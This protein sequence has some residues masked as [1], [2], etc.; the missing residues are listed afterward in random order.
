MLKQ[1]SYNADPII[2]I[3]CIFWKRD[4]Y[5]PIPHQGGASAW[6]AMAKDCVEFPVTL[7]RQKVAKRQATCA[8][9]SLEQET[10]TDCFY[11]LLGIICQVIGRTFTF[12][13]TM[14]SCPFTNIWC[15]ICQNWRPWK[16][17]IPWVTSTHSRT[18]VWE[19]SHGHSKIHSFMP[20]LTTDSSLSV[21]FT[22]ENFSH[23]TCLLLPSLW[24]SY[25]MLYGLCIRFN[26]SSSKNHR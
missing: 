20:I 23:K 12:Q 1:A 8:D 3:F 9:S 14:E 13:G 25:K 2:Q 24:E 15:Y 22:A 17:K 26:L 5:I 11:Y 7:Q 18:K 19:W 21:V 10:Y 4:P 6:S 16:S